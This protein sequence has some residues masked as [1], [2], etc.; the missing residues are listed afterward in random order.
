MDRPLSDPRALLSPLVYVQT[1]LMQPMLRRFGDK[2]ALTV[3]QVA[4]VLKW[5]G[6][7]LALSKWQVYIVEVLG[8]LA[9]MSLPVIS[10]LKA[11]AVR[12]HEQGALQGALSGVQALASGVG[13]VLFYGLFRFCTKVVHALRV[14]LHC[15]WLHH[16]HDNAHKYVTS[17]N[18][19]SACVP[20]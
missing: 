9:F 5:A 14:R 13:P 8:S 10:G 3:A 4:S 20:G 18:V 1:V 19:P 2:G 17:C 6:I 12:Q 16:V 7:A 11:N 15:C